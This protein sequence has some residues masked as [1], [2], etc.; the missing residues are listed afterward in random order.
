MRGG[1]G[2]FFFLVLFGFWFLCKRKRKR[3]ERER[4]RGEFGALLLAVVAGL[5][6]FHEIRLFMC[7]RLWSP[8]RRLL[9]YKK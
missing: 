4:E 3:R 2:F 7:S 9:V 1:L 5:C 8:R 6:I